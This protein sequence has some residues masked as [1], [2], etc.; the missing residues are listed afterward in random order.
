[1]AT[2]SWKDAKF[3]TAITEVAYFENTAMNSEYS[4]IQLGLQFWAAEPDGIWISPTLNET[5]L[6]WLDEAKHL[7]YER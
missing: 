2:L 3:V 1:M 4:E 6:A 7:K 5:N